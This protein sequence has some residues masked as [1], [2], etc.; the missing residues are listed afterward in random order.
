MA[1][2]DPE[3]FQGLERVHVGVIGAGNIF[4][5]YIQGLRMYPLLNV[6][7]V[8]D[9][10]EELAARRGAE[11]NLRAYTVEEMLRVPYI[12]HIVNLTVPQAHAPVN[13]A[14]LNAHKHVYSEKP[15]AVTRQEALDTLVTAT[16]QGYM[17]GCAPDTF[18]GGGIQTCLKLIN[19]GWIGQPVA[20]TAF[21]ASH[22]PEG[23]HPNP[24]FFYQQGGGPL[25]DMG[26]YYITTLIALLGPVRRVAGTARISTPERIATSEAKFGLRIPVEV[27]THIAGTLEM[28]SGVVASVI[29]S[30]DVWHHHMPLIEIHGTEGSLSVPDPNAFGGKPL[31]IRSSSRDWSPVP[32]THPDT[33]L[34]GI[35]VADMA[36]AW[37]TGRPHRAS[38]ALAYHALDVMYSLLESSE[39][40]QYI[41]VK[42]TVA[43]PAPVPLNLLPGTLDGASIG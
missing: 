7:G 19:D 1:V 29:T 11:F 32:L 28:E 4:P 26:P 5:Q 2:R 33:M 3:L 23:W 24:G 21:F 42:S 35:G 8:A 41:E 30:F 31:L 40:G 43:Q 34:R 16:N 15:L 9:L 27:P 38:G 12:S 39:R 37:R 20:A 17:I 13:Q 14:V 25:L 18:L 36:Y 22:G 10:N 6:V